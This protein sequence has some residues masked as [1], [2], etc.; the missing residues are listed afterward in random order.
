MTWTKSIGLLAVLCCA[1]AAASSTPLFTRSLVVDR[2]VNIFTT[3]DFSLKFVFG[4]SFFSPTNPV[5]LF[6]GLIITPA[7]TGQT[8]LADAST[9]PGFADAAQRITDGLNENIRLAFTEIASGRPEQRGWSESGFFINHGSPNIPDLKGMRVDAIELRIDNFSLQFGAPATNPSGATIPPVQLLATFSVYGQVPE[10]SSLALAGA[11][12]LA[13][14][15]AAYTVARRR[16]AEQAARAL[17]PVRTAP[18][19]PRR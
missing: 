16:R 3:T 14:A 11:S 2:S 13:A 7:S 4:N 8:F 18:R 19:T 5:T 10:P 1:P 15:V 6:D 17:A 9:D 12:L